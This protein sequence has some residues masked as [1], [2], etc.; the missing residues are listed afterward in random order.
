[1]VEALFRAKRRGARI[2]EVPVSHR[3]RPHGESQ[4]FTLR[5]AW[6]L[7]WY[8]ARGVVVGRVLGRWR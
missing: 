4:C 6:R 3:A 5:T 2:V 7:A 1:M 8:A